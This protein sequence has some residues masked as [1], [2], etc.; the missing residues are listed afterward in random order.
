[1]PYY[2][3]TFTFGIYADNPEAAAR[4]A[5]EAM[6]DPAAM[7]PIAE[8]TPRIDGPD[9]APGESNDVDLNEVDDL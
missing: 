3:V 8:V 9:G 6:R 4:D 7:P 2:D 5:Y 1:M